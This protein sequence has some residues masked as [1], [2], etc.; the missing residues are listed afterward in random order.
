MLHKIAKGLRYIWPD[1]KSTLWAKASVFSY[2]RY[3]VGPRPL[4]NL[5]HRVCRPTATPETPGAFLCGLRLMAIDGTVE[6]VPDTAEYVA[7]FGRH[8]G[9]RCGGQQIDHGL[10]DPPREAPAH[11]GIWIRQGLPQDRRTRG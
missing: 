7:A 4:A 1:P 6:D 5:F 8:P 10:R 11:L 2:R 9:D 3:Q